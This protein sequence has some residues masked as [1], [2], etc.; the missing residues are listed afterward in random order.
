[1]ESPAIG[2]SAMGASSPLQS[3]GSGAGAALAS[4]VNALPDNSRLLKSTSPSNPRTPAQLAR[5]RPT[6]DLIRQLVVADGRRTRRAAGA[7]CAALAVSLAFLGVTI[8]AIQLTKDTQVDN[9]RGTGSVLVATAAEMGVDGASVQD[10]ALGTAEAVAEVALGEYD[11]DDAALADVERVVVSLADGS[12]A[13][14]AV[15]AAERES[16]GTLA[17][18]G[19]DGRVAYVSAEGVVNYQPPPCVPNAFRPCDDVFLRAD[20]GIAEDADARAHARAHNES[21]AQLRDELA[22][23]SPQALYAVA[24]AAGLLDAVA[25]AGEGAGAADVQRAVLDGALLSGGVRACVQNGML[26]CSCI[27]ARVRVRVHIMRPE[28]DSVLRGSCRARTLRR[29]AACSL[30]DIHALN[31]RT[32]RAHRLYQLPLRGGPTALM[33]P[34]LNFAAAGDC[35]PQRAL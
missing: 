23:I 5:R 18:A 17:L 35:S 31:A 11:L 6:L 1:M 19:A 21:L 26:D 14:F 7:V 34:M 9:T 28:P 8:F 10:S 33:P 24:D 32:T 25:G 4:S 15:V 3:F 13:A 2:G 29:H 16:D 30:T 20:A 12:V 22:M 27:A